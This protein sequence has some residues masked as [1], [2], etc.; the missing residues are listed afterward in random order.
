M[1]FADYLI[2]VSSDLKLS[3]GGGSFGDSIMIYDG[4]PGFRVPESVKIA[5]L[6]VPEDRFSNNAGEIKA[7]EH[8]RKQ[9]YALSSGS[10]G[11]IVDLGNLRTGKTLF[12]TYFGLQHLF[13]ELYSQG[14][15]TLVIGGTI[16]VGYG[17]YLAFNGEKINLT[18][19]APHLRLPVYG[20]GEQPL[21]SLIFDEAHL[22]VRCCNI[23]YQSYYVMQSDLD[24]LK[25]KYA[26]IYR[27]GEVRM[28]IRE[29]EPVIRDSDLLML[30]M[31]AVKYSDAPAA[32]ISSPNGFSGEDVCQLAHYAGLGYRCKSMGIFDI[33]PQDDYRNITSKLAAQIGWYFIEGVKRRNMDNPKDTIQNFK[34]YMI[35]F[36]QLHHNLCFYKNIKTERWWME[37]PS[38]KEDQPGEIISCTQE[39]YTR[40]AEQEIPDRWWKMYQRI[41]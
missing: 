30:S 26:E 28:N 32:S 1:N 5:I 19:I 38:L 12:D 4:E 8:I 14:I 18:S 7:P 21:N 15:V 41:N 24:F 37:V 20:I 35:Y 23:G 22:P 3:A 13:E 33:V 25:G 31:N 34:K 40:A 16:D 6:G 27:L 39:D 36:D 9:L 2:P 29:S 17:N 11:T 10:P